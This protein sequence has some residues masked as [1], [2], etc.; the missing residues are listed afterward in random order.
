MLTSSTDERDVVRSYENG[1][2][3]FVAKPVTKEDLQRTFEYFAQ[4]WSQ[5]AKLPP[6]D[7]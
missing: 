4:Y 2:S 3:T 1:A 7:Q 6:Q 5:M